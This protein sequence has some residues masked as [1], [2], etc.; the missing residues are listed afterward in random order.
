MS[1]AT[2]QE[3]ARISGRLSKAVKSASPEKWRGIVRKL[4]RDIDN[5]IDRLEKGRAGKAKK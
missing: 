2:E 1:Q 3:L 4:I 5:T